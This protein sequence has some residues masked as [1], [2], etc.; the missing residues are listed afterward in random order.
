MNKYELILD[1]NQARE[2]LKAVEL[3]MRLKLSQHEELSRAILEPMWDRI[4]CDEFCRRRDNANQYLKPAFS[5][6]L[7]TMEDR[8]K[9][10][11]FNILYNLYQALRYAICCAETPDST[12]VNSNPP[13][14][15]NSE[16]IP[17]CFLMFDT[18]SVKPVKGGY[19]NHAW[20]CGACHTPV[21]IVGDDSK[22]N[23]CPKCGN[24][25]DW[26]V[27]V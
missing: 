9:D 10:K 18:D 17:L 7:P 1:S 5:Y 19:G 4:G 23:F 3:L 24:K 11:E 2:T 22:C 16:P 20:E 13:S 12:G 8:Q 21:G 6:L 26:S 27:E 14:H 15:L 25:V